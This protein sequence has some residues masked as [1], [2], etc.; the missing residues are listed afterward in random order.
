MGTGGRSRPWSH[1]AGKLAG[2]RVAGR[3]AGKPAGSLAGETIAVGPGNVPGRLVS[4]KPGTRRARRLL[5]RMLAV[6]LPRRRSTGERARRRRVRRV[7][8]RRTVVP[9]SVVPRGP[10]VPLAR[11]SARWPASI[12][13]PVARPGVARSPVARG[14][15][16]RRPVGSVS[17]GWAASRTPRGGFTGKSGA[18]G[19]GGVRKPGSSP[20]AGTRSA[21]LAT[22][23]S[24]AG[25]A[26]WP[27][28]GIGLRLPGPA[29]R[30]RSHGKDRR[31]PRARRHPPLGNRV[32][33]MTSPSALS[34]AGLGP[35]GTT[36]SAVSPQ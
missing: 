32:S 8:R 13:P 30:K 17:T 1:R 22:A 4:G 35:T 3:S 14:G 10:V 36:T 28:A 12:L 27:G 6:S 29:P 21:A 5:E 26:V 2:R 23:V 31:Q 7:A 24:R 11:G 19:R 33:A 18:S 15:K 20:P 9:G 25:A 16:V 34:Q